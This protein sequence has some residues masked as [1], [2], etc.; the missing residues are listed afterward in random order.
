MQT[1]E[2]LSKWYAKVMYV[3]PYIYTWDV[4]DRV[5]ISF[6]KDENMQTR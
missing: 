5:N 6:T 1:I 4:P 2:F 3:P